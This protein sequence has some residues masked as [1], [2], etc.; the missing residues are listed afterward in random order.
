MTVDAVT[1]PY[2]AGNY[3]PT[4]DQEL[5]LRAALLTGGEAEEAWRRLRPRLALDTMDVASRRLLPLLYRNLRRLGIVDP[6]L[7]TLKASYATTW[8]QNQEIF[9]DVGLLL[10]RLAVAGIPTLL[11]KGAALVHG[12]YGGDRG[13]RPMADFDVAVPVGRTREAVEVLGRAGWTPRYPVTPSFM[14]VK[15]AIAFESG[16]RRPCD[17]H[18]YVFEECCRPGADDDLWRASVEIE[19]QGARTRVLSPPDLLLHVCVHGTKWAHTPGIRWIADAMTVLRHD[20]IDWPRVVEVARR[21][22]YVLRMRETLGFLR[23]R[24]AAPV[25]DSALGPLTQEPVGPLE[26]FEYRVLRRDHRL[27][28]Q[29][30]LYWC[31]HRRAHDGGPVSAALAFPTFLR[32]AWGLQTLREVPRGLLVRARRRL[33]RAIG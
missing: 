28:G 10:E 18:W 32:H 6:A 1:D 13:L 23:E 29:L 31:H 16:A 8:A 27:L 4:P 17:L 11:L 3:W 26:R 14:R 2:R 12:G 33:G 21:R 15:H 9:R 7:G 19:F 25:P 24:L 5:L 30:P 20:P 22:R